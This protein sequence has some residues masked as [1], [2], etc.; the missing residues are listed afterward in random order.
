MLDASKLVV[1][2]DTGRW[3]GAS[4]SA[5]NIDGSAG[6]VTTLGRGIAVGNG[7]HDFQ[8]DADIRSSRSE[9]AVIDFDEDVMLDE[10]GLRYLER[11]EWM[12]RPETG[13]WTA[14]DANGATMATG[15]FAHARVDLG[16]IDGVRRLIIKATRY[17]HGT[18]GGRTNNQ[19]DFA[20]TY[21]TGR[22]DGTGDAGA[23]ATGTGIGGTGA[24]DGAGNRAG[25]GG[26]G[27]GGRTGTGGIATGTGIGGAGT[28]AGS[29]SGGAGTGTGTG[30]RTGTSGTATGTG[31]GGAG[32]GAGSGSGGAGTGG[33][34]TGA[35]AGA[36]AGGAGTGVGSGTGGAGAGAG[37]PSA[38]EPRAGAIARA[39]RGL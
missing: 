26:T 30:G 18:A 34:G 6:T 28:G 37:T 23:G 13:R 29:G 5:V 17:G 9:A 38:Q 15:A 39:S 11:S 35:G 19:S 1:S 12:G 8:I 2:G 3:P 7:R 4:I 33:A 14:V 24:G 20:I 31:I 25:T 27:T 36:G 21:V 16:G 32:T 10:I 22:T